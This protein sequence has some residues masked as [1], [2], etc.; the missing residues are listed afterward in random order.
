MEEDNKLKEA[1]IDKMSEE[2]EK[3]K[4]DIE[5]VEKT[6]KEK[7]DII[8]ELKD[9]VSYYFW[10]KTQFKKDLPLMNLIYFFHLLTSQWLP[11]FG[12]LLI[13]LLR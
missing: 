7:D 12:N 5:E 8:N 13:I 1:A 9:A 2:V 4:E 11:V 6:V 3:M 10:E